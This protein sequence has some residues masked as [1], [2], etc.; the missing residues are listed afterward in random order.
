MFMPSFNN[1]TNKSCGHILYPRNLTSR[2]KTEMKLFLD[3]I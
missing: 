3:D 2:K 1:N